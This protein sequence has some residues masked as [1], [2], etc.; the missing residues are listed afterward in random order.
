MNGSKIIG[1]LVSVISLTSVAEFQD[2]YDSQF[3]AQ[4][5]IDRQMRQQEMIERNREYQRVQSE[6]RRRN[7]EE[8]MRRIEENNR[9]QAEVRRRNQEESMRRMQ[10]NNI[11]MANERAARD[12]TRIRNIPVQ[13]SSVQSVGGV[14][15]RREHPLIIYFSSDANSL[16][17]ESIPQGASG[18]IDYGGNESRW[19]YKGMSVWEPSQYPPPPH[20][21]VK[22]PQDR[23]LPDPIEEFSGVQ[24]FKNYQIQLLSG[25]Q[26]L[27]DFQQTELFFSIHYNGSLLSPKSDADWRDHF[28]AF[29]NGEDRGHFTTNEKGE[30]RFGNGVFSLSFSYEIDGVRYPAYGNFQTNLSKKMAAHSIAVLATG[31]AKKITKAMNSFVGETP[32]P[33]A[34]YSVTFPFRLELPILA[35]CQKSGFTFNVELDGQ[36]RIE[37]TIDGTTTPLARLSPTTPGRIQ[38]ACDGS[39]LALVADHFTP[40][41][42]TQVK[43]KG[44]GVLIDGRTLVA[45][46]KPVLGHEFGHLEAGSSPSRGSYAN[47]ALEGLPYDFEV[48]AI[49][50]KLLRPKAYPEGNCQ[51]SGTYHFQ[52][53]PTHEKT[54]LT[55]VVKDRE[56][57]LARFRGITRADCAGDKLSVIAES[58]SY[59]ETIENRKLELSEPNSDMVP[60]GPDLNPTDG[61]GLYL[62]EANRFVLARSAGKNEYFARSSLQSKRGQPVWRVTFKD[63]TD[64]FLEVPP[65]GKSV[66]LRP[67]SF[68]SLADQSEFDLQLDGE[69]IEIVY[70]S[71]IVARVGA[72]VEA[73]AVQDTLAII[74]SQVE[75]EKEM[76]QG[77]LYFY[78]KDRNVLKRPAPGKSAFHSLRLSPQSTFLVSFHDGRRELVAEVAR[79]ASSLQVRS[80]SPLHASC[81]GAPF[82]FI[83]EP[84]SEI[85]IFSTKSGTQ[86]LLAAVQDLSYVACQGETIALV[87]S[88]LVLAGEKETK[89]DGLFFFD[90]TGF[91]GA[92]PHADQ[93]W[94][95]QPL[96]DPSKDFLVGLENSPGFHALVNPKGNVKWVVDRNQACTHHLYDFDDQGVLNVSIG[97]EGK[98]IPA[99]KIM[100]VSSVDC[101]G[102]AVVFV[103]R[104]ME[105]DTQVVKI[106]LEG[107]SSNVGLKPGKEIIQSEVPVVGMI[108]GD[109][110]RLAFT[111]KELSAGKGSLVRAG[112]VSATLPGIRVS[113][114]TSPNS[115]TGFSLTGK[116]IF[117]AWISPG[118]DCN[119]RFLWEDRDQVGVFLTE[120][121]SERIASLT[122]PRDLQCRGDSLMFFGKGR[123]FLAGNLKLALQDS[124]VAARGV[125]RLDQLNADREYAFFIR[126]GTLLLIGE[127]PPGKSF[128]RLS[129]ASEGTFTVWVGDSNGYRIEVEAD[130]TAHAEDWREP[131]AAGPS[132]FEVAERKLLGGSK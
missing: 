29:L 30:V 50:E 47:F 75:G 81:L 112:Q 66:H 39:L 5:A 77:S 96:P 122:S 126:G 57:P 53:S 72:L 94:W 13:S 110:L 43:E 12:W 65:S 32:T 42:G 99:A 31:R 80:A 86:K 9:V 117:P 62:F 114:Q 3:R 76:G 48:N 46:T 41:N 78:T 33:V 27:K 1:L 119:Y 35:S 2:S 8:T 4:E 38:V 103:F 63:K 97:S 93:R 129:A 22:D 100:D 101:S 68:E 107:S 127:A 82:D 69:I 128:L 98:W 51:T 87:A 55:Q 49:G 121:N 116:K 23:P 123:E 131:A 130:G 64:R 79:D 92:V 7:H 106:G 115:A 89:A 52:Y 26:D 105:L 56:I 118:S 84:L 124:V 90:S 113:H 34:P 28:Q 108:V 16:N 20:L 83:F 58:A 60:E 6:I 70:G 17:G 111:Q 11:R 132:F 15:S 102:Q 10:E 21:S 74:A 18:R 71:Q 91:V 36:I 19:Y 61:N 59:H 104:R 85:R 25:T 24:N 125:S 37:R 14:E 120:E 45:T 54:I 67:G 44:L 95:A 109:Q 73:V 88:G 40:E